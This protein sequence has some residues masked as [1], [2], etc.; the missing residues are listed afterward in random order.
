[1]LTT[2]VFVS[3]L[4]ISGLGILLGGYYYYKPESIV[5]KRVKNSH[6]KAARKDAEFR[7]WLEAE[8]NAQVTKTR[9]MGMII[10]V[11]EAILMVLCFSLWQKG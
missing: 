6:W 10:I 2:P 4:V 5:K 7:K 11:V 3:L 9:R 1:M 8:I